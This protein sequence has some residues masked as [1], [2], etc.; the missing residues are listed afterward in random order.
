MHELV[1]ELYPICRSLTGNGV[2]ETLGI[3]QGHAPIA[4]HEVPTGTPIFD[5]TAPKEWNIRAATLR[6]PR[7]NVVVDFAAHNLHVVGY[8]VPVQRR[9]PL[10]ELRPHLFSLPEQPDAIPYRT[11]YYK[12]DWG[13]C[14]TQRQMDALEDGEYEVRIDSS[15]ETGSLTYGEC[16]LA[17]ETE[18][19]ILISTHICHPSMCNDNLAG[20]AVA[21]FLSQWYGKA[22]RRHSL[23]ILFVPGTL[24]AIAW[25]AKNQSTTKRIRHGLVLTCIGDG[26]AFTY[27]RSRRGNAI[28]DRAAEH[29]LRHSGRSWSAIDFSPYGYDE[30]Q[31]CSPGF[32]LPVGCLM[33]TPHGQFPEYHTSS[34]DLSFVRPENLAESL[35]TCKAILEAVDA[36]RRWINLS[37]MCE[38]QLGRRGLYNRAGAAG[39]ADA[40]MARLWVLNFSDG[41]HSLL[42]IAERAR[43]PFSAVNAA[44]RELA[45]AG[46]L[47]AQETP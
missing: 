44:S 26:G 11:S 45:A 13:F 28:V 40:E 14:L 36:D 4:I 41:E 24:G 21:T 39:P 47:A 32:N 19:E 34:D 20:I 10:A 8:S 27:K 5:W 3:L 31:Y 23:R 6:G 33:R 22:P 15:L 2:R 35:E 38:P 9:M 17:G 16:F 42:D 30:R 25:L 1:S 18:D 46:L 43:L 12:P 7:G 29:V 37:P